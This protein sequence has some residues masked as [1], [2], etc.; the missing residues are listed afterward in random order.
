[1]DRQ[2]EAVLLERF[3][4]VSQKVFLL[5]QFSTS[6][7]YLDLEIPDPYSGSFEEVIACFHYI[8]SCFSGLI[9]ELHNQDERL[10]RRGQI[11]CWDQL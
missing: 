4:N 3:P 1:M 9:R 6:Q 11:P 2:N 7:R 8:A 5:A 10:L